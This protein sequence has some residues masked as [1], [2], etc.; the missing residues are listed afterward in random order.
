[1]RGGGRGRQ[2]KRRACLTLRPR[3]C[4]FIKS[5]CFFRK[6]PVIQC[7]TLVAFHIAD[8]SS[9]LDFGHIRT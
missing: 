4:A 5:W 8:P 6:F 9:I 2:F 7:N 3:G 1:M